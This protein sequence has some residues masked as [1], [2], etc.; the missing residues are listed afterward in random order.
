[1]KKVSKT[2]IQEAISQELSKKVVNEKLT[3]IPSNIFGGIKNVASGLKGQ[4]NVGKINN[5]LQR[6]AERLDKEWQSTVDTTEK[7]MHSMAT[8]SNA[9]VR[10]SAQTVWK[11]LVSADGDVKKA[12]QKLK[13]TSATGVNR[14]A[15]PEQ[16]G[17][18]PANGALN[19][20]DSEDDFAEIEKVTKH[21]TKYKEQSVDRWL[22]GL[23]LN[24]EKIGVHERNQANKLFLDLRMKGIN[25][26]RMSPEQVGELYSLSQV[27]EQAMKT[28]QGDPFPNFEHFEKVL[29]K[30]AADDLRKKSQ[31]RLKKGLPAEESPS[32][33]NMFASKEGPNQGVPVSRFKQATPPAPA[34]AAKPPLDFSQELK[35][36][37]AAPAAPPQA[38]PVPA[39]PESPRI[40]P[41]RANRPAAQ[42]RN[43]NSQQAGSSLND[44]KQVVADPEFHL[45]KQE[46]EQVYNILSTKGLRPAFLEFKKLASIARSRPRI[47][48]APLVDKREPVQTTPNPPPAAPPPAV[49][50][51]SS[52][53]K[54]PNSGFEPATPAAQASTPQAV[55]TAPTVAVGGEEEEPDPIPLV[56]KK[57]NQMEVPLPPKSSNVVRPKKPKKLV[58]PSVADTFSNDPR[59][60]GSLPVQDNG[61]EVQV[62]SPEVPGFGPTK[63]RVSAKKKS[64]PKKKAAKKR[65]A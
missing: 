38:T 54:P 49:Q 47:G 28:G 13:N 9:D 39:A 18:S 19:L 56:S 15:E 40:G 57:P 8:S 59:M 60:G 42:A 63:E 27:R 6:S 45:T 11:N 2:I 5:Q 34:D 22:K 32:N 3:D 44:F 52:T 53:P 50:G 17:G 51:V 16:Q 23:G 12:I 30:A 43:P 61:T 48:N 33:Q 4:Y 29:G 55:A 7:A 1:M 20:M 35:S 31:E 37:P 25:P 21:G 36:E 58:I 24:P 10:A 26:F 46:I 64:P 65:K 14:A 41:N 62:G